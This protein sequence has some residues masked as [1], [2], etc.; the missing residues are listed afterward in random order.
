MKAERGAFAFVFETEIYNLIKRDHLL[1][2]TDEKAGVEDPISEII[3]GEQAM[4]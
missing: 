1:L 4:K 2:S 3:L